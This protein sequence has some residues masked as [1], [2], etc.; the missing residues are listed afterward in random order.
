MN[1]HFKT[2]AS[3][4]GNVLRVVAP[5]N[6]PNRFKVV[7]MCKTAAGV[8]KD[9]QLFATMVREAFVLEPYAEVTLKCVGH[10]ERFER[11]NHFEHPFVEGKML[12]KPAESR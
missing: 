4:D 1:Y 6:Y 12:P 2:M 7:K 9:N 10:W 3:A 8:D 5:S 11:E